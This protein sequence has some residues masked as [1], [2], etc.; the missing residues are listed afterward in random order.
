MKKLLSLV[1]FLFIAHCTQRIAGT[2]DETVTGTQAMVTGVLFEPN[3]KTPAKGASVSMRRKTSLAD[4]GQSTN[5]QP[6]STASVTTDRNGK[7]A[8]DTID[9]GLYIIEGNDGSNNVVLID[10]IKIKSPDSSKNL[11]TDTL[12]PAGVI[13]GVIKLIEG[14]DPRKVFVLA[15]GLDRFALP[16]ANG[17][18]TFPTLAKG[19]YSLRFLPS[20]ENYGVLDTTGV[21]VRSGDTMNLDTIVLPFKGI[22]SPKNLVISYDTLKQTVILNWVKADTS[23][24]SAYN[25]YRSDNKQNFKRISQTPVP[26]TATVY[27]D[28]NVTVGGVYEYRVV[29]LN[30]SGNESSMGGTPGDTVKAISSSQVITKLNWTVSNVVSGTASIYDTIKFRLGYQNPTRKINRIEWYLNQKD[31]V[32]KQSVDSSLAGKD[33]VI[34]SWDKVGKNTVYVHVIDAGGTVWAD[35]QIVNIIQDVPSVTVTGSNTTAVINAPIMTIIAGTPVFLHGNATQLFGTIVKRQWKIGSGNWETSLG[36]DTSIIASFSEQT[37]AC[38]LA[39][40]DD[41]ENR[42]I[43]AIQVRVIFGIIK[44]SSGSGFSLILKSDSTLWACGGNGKGQLGVGDYENR[45]VPVMVMRGVNDMSAGFTHSLILKTDG[46]LWGCGEN[47]DGQL[48]DGT[49]TNHALPI[50]IMSEVQGMKASRS[51]FVG[52]S[53]IIKKGGDLWA[54]GDNS[55][56]QLGDGTKNSSLFPVLIMPNV[57]NVTAGGFNGLSFIIKLD[58]TLWAC[59]QNFGGSLGDTSYIPGAPPIQIMSPVQNVATGDFDHSLFLKTDNTLWASGVNSDGELGDGT[60]NSFLTPT[61]ITAMD[62]VIDISAGGGTYGGYSLFLKADSTLWASGNNANGTLGNG[63]TISQ[64]IPLQVMTNVKSMSAGATHSLVL[65]ADGTLW[66]FGKND[67]GEL[68][69]G[70]TANHSMP[71]QIILPPS[72][73]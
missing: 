20:L 57:K 9:T 2:T 18:F 54:C 41:D 58:N 70:T 27:Y 5:A 36:M 50:R 15:F 10:S 66:G 21:P 6:F 69:D 32:A 14:G 45:T 42:G 29:S 31:S 4:T 46:T 39:I 65:K 37:I 16:D 61:Q 72:I 7:F 59:G 67:N 47:Q 71:M 56:G 49:T 55:Y 63:T 19:N 22:P 60:R 52:F 24:F 3:G 12:L 23:L 11:G 62:N 8:I 13:K 1:L 26:K 44:I 33:S 48:G 73:D 25:I 64:I 35:S 34:F 40:T 68:G 30:A 43:G 28:S 53:L 51:L 17:N 38:S